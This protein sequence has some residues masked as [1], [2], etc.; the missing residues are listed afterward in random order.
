VY[1]TTD[2]RDQLQQKAPAHAEAMAARWARR[3]GHP[4][5]PP[6]KSWADHYSPG[7]AGGGPAGV[8]LVDG[9]RLDVA[10]AAGLAALRDGFGS[11][12]PD[13]QA[14]CGTCPSCT[15]GSPSSCRRPVSKAMATLRRKQ[16]AD[17]GS[18]VESAD[19]LLSLVTAELA[20]GI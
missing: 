11:V 20:M 12:L 7:M 2:L 17:P 10:M 4:P 18:D 15:Y 8:E 13:G 14:P 9:A 1:F 16:A 6:G 5:P 3:W 19:A